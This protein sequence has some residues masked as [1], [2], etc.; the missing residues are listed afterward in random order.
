M[1]SKPNAKKTAQL[2][3]ILAEISRRLRKIVR[4]ADILGGAQPVRG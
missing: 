3:L 4:R 1:A 2:S